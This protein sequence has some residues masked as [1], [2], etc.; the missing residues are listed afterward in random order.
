VAPEAN[1]IETELRDAAADTADDVRN[2]EE[3]ALDTARNG[4]HKAQAHIEENPLMSAAIAFA[5]GA[6]LSMLI[7]R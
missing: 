6:L 1:R 7:R 2:L 4:M 5:A 3:Q